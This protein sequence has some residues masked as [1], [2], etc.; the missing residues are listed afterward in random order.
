MKS[1][2][3]SVTPASGQFTVDSIE[4]PT[5][6]SSDYIELGGSNYT[7]ADLRWRVSGTQVWN[8]VNDVSEGDTIGSVTPGNIDVQTRLHNS[9]GFGLWSNTLTNVSIS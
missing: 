5:L 9:T 3:P 8:T 4:D 6:Y 7:Q 1:E 2:S